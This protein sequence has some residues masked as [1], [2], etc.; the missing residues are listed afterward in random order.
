VPKRDDILLDDLVRSLRRRIADFG[1]ESEEVQEHL[2]RLIWDSTLKR[3]QHKIYTDWMSITYQELYGKFGR[4]GFRAVNDRLGLFEVNDNYSFAGDGGKRQ[5]YTKGYRLTGKAQTAKSGFLHS[6]IRHV[7]KLIGGDGR[8]LRTPPK[9]VASKD[10]EGITASKWKN[11]KFK[12]TVPMDIDALK[13]LRKRLK[14]I[15]KDMKAGHWNSDLFFKEETLEQ[16][17]YC[18]EVVAQILRLA[19]TDVAEGYVIHRYVESKAGRLYAKNINLQT[20]P[21]AVKQAALHGLWEYDFENC[22]YSIFQQLAQQA[23][24][25]C[26]NIQHYLAHKRVVRDQIA[27]EIQ[28]T[29]DQAKV[30]LIAIMYG[31]R[32]SVWHESAIPEAV[33]DKAERLYQHPL[34]KGLM[35]E[36]RAG[37]EAILAG[38]PDKGRTTYRNM[39]GKRIKKKESNEKILAHLIQGIEARM[40]NIVL[41]LY[42]E[43]IL[44]LQHDGFAA[45]NRLDRNLITDK[46]SDETGFD[47]ALD[48][49]RIQVTP[50]IIFSKT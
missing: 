27:T 26:P 21:R 47:M 33:G 8:Y 11:T 15:Q 23:G 37:R 30:C 34:F 49:A 50:E 32:E 9:A 42:P 13:K 18:L 2:A 10:M 46:I 28:I 35:G 45:A 20:T 40:L 16:V 3:R 6:N 44:L 25:D 41:D 22:H 36:I 24:V 43:D 38:W 5:Q 48:E 39:M 19:H 31:A 29:V 14:S 1:K 12:S 7:S 17:E 4:N